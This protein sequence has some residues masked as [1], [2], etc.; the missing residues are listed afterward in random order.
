MG[1]LVSD[2]TPRLPAPIPLNMNAAQLVAALLALESQ[3]VAQAPRIYTSTHE[4]V[5][6]YVDR[7]QSDVAALRDS[8]L[9]PLVLSRAELDRQLSQS[10]LDGTFA[11]AGGVR[12]AG[13]FVLRMNHGLPPEP[14]A[15]Y[16]P[17]A[18]RD[19]EPKSIVLILHGAG[20]SETDVAGVPQF[21]RLAERTN[22]IIVAPWAEGSRTFDDP[23]SEEILAALDTV[24]RAYR[25]DPRRVY[26]AG[27]SMGVAGAL[28]LVAN[29]HVQ[30]AAILGIIG[31]VNPR[32][33][34]ALRGPLRERPLYLVNGGRDPVMTPSIVSFTF[35]ALQS[36]DE[37]T[38][39]YLSPDAG[40]SLRDTAP[41]IEQAWSDMFAGTIRAPQ[42]NAAA[43]N[44][45]MSARPS[46][47][48]KP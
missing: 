6:E 13:S 29:S 46:S 20:E 30:F 18:A 28:H 5:Y 36:M 31:D 15:I 19:E 22:A 12:G 48:L 1:S 27:I 32:D 17:H 26:I 35:S 16:V 39:L 9:A 47:S 43:L 44:A 4:N 24:E 8:S 37:F 21:Q 38:S 40:H 3:L 14:V 7:L 41:Q 34:A 10:L 33:L 2:V 25:F 11:P 23:A 42:Q 45:L